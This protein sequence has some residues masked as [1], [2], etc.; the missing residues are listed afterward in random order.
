L[1]VDLTN[2][3]T[4]IVEFSNDGGVTWNAGTLDAAA[5]PNTFCY[6]FTETNTTCDATMVTYQAQFNA[7]SLTDTTCDIDAQPIAGGATVSVDVY[8]DIATAANAMLASDGAC[9]PSLTQDCSSFIVTNDYDT[10]G[11]AP[12]FTNEMSAGN[13]NPRRN[14]K[15]IEVAFIFSEYCI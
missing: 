5:M 10:N 2:D 11:S 7:G 3:E 6:D 4:A 12:D 15:K 1:C 8:P 9:G 13:V 14:P